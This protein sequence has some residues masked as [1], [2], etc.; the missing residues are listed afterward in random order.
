MIKA[1]LYQAVITNLWHKLRAS[2]R[3]FAP[4]RS[5]GYV[6]SQENQYLA[7]SFAPQTRR[8]RHD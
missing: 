3:F 5:Y 7:P 8:G 1:W 2:Y 4:Q 6:L